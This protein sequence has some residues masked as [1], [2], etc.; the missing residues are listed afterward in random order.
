MSERRNSSPFAY[1]DFHEM[2]KVSS[3]C[4]NY[5]SGGQPLYTHLRTAGLIFL[6]YGMPDVGLVVTTSFGTTR[7][8]LDN[9]LTWAFQIPSNEIDKDQLLLLRKGEGEW[10]P[11]KAKATTIA[12]VTR[13]CNSRLKRNSL[14]H[15]RHLSRPEKYTISSFVKADYVLLLIYDCYNQDI[16]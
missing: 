9:M 3:P 11:Y 8:L 2:E 15:I 12:A 1:M 10:V 14:P 5:A 4:I 6:S 7:E 13:L 16:R